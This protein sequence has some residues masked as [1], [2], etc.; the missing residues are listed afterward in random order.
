MGQESNPP[1]LLLIYFTALINWYTSKEA[2]YERIKNPH[3]YDFP[4]YSAIITVRS[5]YSRLERRTLSM[6][7]AM[8]AERGTNR[9]QIDQRFYL[10]LAR[11]DIPGTEQALSELTKP[12]AIFR[13]ENDD[14]GYV[15]DL[16]STAAVLYAKIA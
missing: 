8:P 6:L 12:S 4:G 7:T 16:L 9:Y 1:W 14:S 3:T 10:V 2:N 13:I 15:A 5:D 11:S